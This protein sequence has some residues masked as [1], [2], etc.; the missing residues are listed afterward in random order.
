MK[1]KKTR[2]AKKIGI[3]GG[4]QLARLLALKAPALGLKAAVL[5]PSHDDPAAQAAE[6]WQKGDPRKAS[7]LARFLKTADI[8]TFESEF[9]PARQVKNALRRAFPDKTPGSSPA[10]E[11][12]IAPSL[13]AI[14]LIQD[15]LP[16]KRLLQKFQIET[17]EFEPVSFAAPAAQNQA[18][19]KAAREKLAAVWERLGPFVL[20]T[21][22]GGYDGHG[23]FVIQSK[24]RIRQI[25]P[26]L[27]KLSRSDKAKKPGI[28]KQKQH[29]R[30]FI[31]E[32]YIPF[33]RELAILA[34]RNRRGEA[35]FFP[36][37][38]TRQEQARCLWV[39]GPVSHKKLNF[40]KRK[41]KIFLEG[42]Q[43][44]G[45]MAF[46][47][48]DTGRGLLVNE[49]APRVHNSGHYSLDSLTDDQFSV[50]LKAIAGLPL[51]RPRPLKGKKAFAMLNLL[52]EGHKKP[53][54]PAPKGMTVCWYGKKESRKGRK[55]GHLNSWGH[56]PARALDRLL[57]ARPLFKI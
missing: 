46:E 22:T 39:R 30:F 29:N 24:S 15:R 28:F 23:T 26:V 47:L 11:P 50:H 49:L 16:Q 18:A 41:I 51:A 38:E 7:D 9:I 6:S 36:L 33:K 14:S 42:L 25:M 57:K 48:F 8:I 5:S 52:G 3:L 53:K 2:P 43:Y 12:A 20:K 40:L 45:V 32:K 19:P 31:A 35:V 27:F 56:S 54:L 4:G 1:A 21:R 34:A 17:A 10:R 55:M 13:Q 44:E 37:A